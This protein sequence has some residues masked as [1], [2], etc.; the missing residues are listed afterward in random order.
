[1]TTYL[2]SLAVHVASLEKTTKHLVSA[3]DE[4]EAV[5]I[6]LYR[7]AHSDLDE[8]NEGLWEETCER[9]VCYA[10]DRIQEIPAKDVKILSKYL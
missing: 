6:A 3:V 8:E 7:E 1:M 5:D 9:S 4:R 10:V 2:V